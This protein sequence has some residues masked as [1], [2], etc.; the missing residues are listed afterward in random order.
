M[1]S[2]GLL[3][4]HANCNGSDQNACLYKLIWFFTD[5]ACDKTLFLVSQLVKG[6]WVHLPILSTNTETTLVTSYSLFASP[7]EETLLY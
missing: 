6:E 1:L 2:Y 7:G 5:C 3:T 4:V